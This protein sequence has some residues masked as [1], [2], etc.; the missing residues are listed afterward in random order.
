MV[1]GPGPRE[2]SMDRVH[3]VVHGPGPQA[4]RVVHGPGPRGWSMDLGPCFVYVPV[5]SHSHPAQKAFGHLAIERR[6][7]EALRDVDQSERTSNVCKESMLIF[8]K[9]INFFSNLNALL[10]VKPKDFWY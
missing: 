2:W 7:G 6:F 9:R 1:H 5:K 3:E 4:H 10:I 8:A